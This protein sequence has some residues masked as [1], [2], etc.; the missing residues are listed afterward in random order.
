MQIPPKGPFF[1]PDPGFSGRTTGRH[2]RFGRR[3]PAVRASPRP[4]RAFQVPA[5]GARSALW[6]GRPRTAG[7]IQPGPRRGPLPRRGP[8]FPRGPTPAGEPRRRPA[9][10]AAG[11]RGASRGG[12]RRGGAAGRRRWRSG[13]GARRPP[14]G[15][16]G[17]G[18]APPPRPRPQPPGGHIAELST[19]A[20]PLLSGPRSRRASPSLPPAAA[21][22]P[23]P[24]SASAAPVG[25][26]LSG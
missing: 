13:R 23:G 21:V 8:R 22:P 5:R 1:S 25:G 26:R 15:R 24:R 17:H 2:A 4:P 18:A 7:C 9:L 20:A 16:G 14:G 3:S 11:S 19:A 10:G 6:A 12:A